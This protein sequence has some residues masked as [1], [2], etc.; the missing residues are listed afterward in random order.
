MEEIKFVFNCSEGNANTQ[1]T[2]SA[3]AE[4]F[5]KKLERLRKKKYLP[6]PVTVDTKTDKK[7]W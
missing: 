2:N 7:L 5:R 1:Y 3:A 4:E 6:D